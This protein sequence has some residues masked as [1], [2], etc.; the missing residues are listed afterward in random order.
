VF[1]FFSSSPSRALGR[2]GLFKRNFPHT[3]VLCFSACAVCIS[4]SLLLGPIAGFPALETN[5]ILCGAQAF[6]IQF[7]GLTG[8]AYYLCIVLNIFFIVVL[9]DIEGKRKLTRGVFWGQHVFAPGLGLLS[10]SLSIGRGDYGFRGMWCWIGGTP[11]WLEMGYFYGPMFLFSLICIFLWV[12][13]VIYLGRNQRSFG[14]L[15]WSVLARHLIFT[16]IFFTLFVAM[17][18][19][20]LYNAITGRDIFVLMELHVIVL[21]GI[22]TWLFLC[23]ALSKHN[24]LLW[25]NMCRNGYTS[26]Q[27]SSTRS[28][29]SFDAD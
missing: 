26:L 17:F 27:D 4:A 9:K 16:A 24:Y 1:F 23:F 19:H 7:F 29:Q 5:S 13:I 12:G 21:A 15:Y 14:D 28:V 3:G 6:L 20:R 8:V 25:R 22:G 18:S 10:A 11:P 2:Y